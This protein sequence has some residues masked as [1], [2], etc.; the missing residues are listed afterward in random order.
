MPA[1][2]VRPGVGVVMFRCAVAL[3]LLMI[4]AVLLASAQ[5]SA[6]DTLPPGAVARLGDTR[7][8]AGGSVER[9]DFSADGTH[10]TAVTKTPDL[11]RRTTWNTKTWQPARAAEEVQQVGAIV[12][13]K[14]N[15]F[16]D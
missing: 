1:R 9:L 5:A 3:F 11:A 2:K 6:E 13:L 4:S 12:R 15:S 7:F 10:L 16:P 14:P 8:L